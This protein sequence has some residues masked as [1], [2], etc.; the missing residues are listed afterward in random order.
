MKE[1]DIVASMLVRNGG[2][3][4][5]RR[6]LALF[7]DMD[8]PSMGV[9]RGRSLISNRHT[10]GHGTYM[11]WLRSFE[12]FAAILCT[13]DIMRQAGINVLRAVMEALDT[14]LQHAGN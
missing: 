1:C 3:Q 12:K 13:T 10:G 14:T 2:E 9:W 7:M 4:E 8:Q 5:A 6:A 11:C